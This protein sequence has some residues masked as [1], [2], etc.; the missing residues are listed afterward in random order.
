[1]KRLSFVASIA[2]TFVLLTTNVPADA[3][4]KADNPAH[5]PNKISGTI[6]SS[7]RAVAS[8]MGS[9]GY[10]FRGVKRALRKVGVELHGGQ[11]FMA[12]GQLES[13]GGFRKVPMKNLQPGDI[14]VHGKSGAHPHGHIAVY[15]GNGKE[16]SDHIGKLVTGRRY[17]GTTVFRAVTNDLA[18]ASRKTP[19]AVV[20]K[21]PA[22]T[23]AAVVAKAPAKT[24]A[25]VV[26][27]ATSQEQQPVLVAA[28]ESKATVQ[29][30][31]AAPLATEHAAEQ[32]AQI[33]AANIA[34]QEAAEATEV[35]EAPQAVVAAQPQPQQSFQLPN[36]LSTALLKVV[37]IAQSAHINLTNA[38]AEAVGAI[39]S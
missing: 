21:A 20:A 7:A 22:K 29:L 17:G 34:Q 31:S 18:S 35:V 12:K 9:V 37:E 38:L 4:K 30:A 24:P 8:S 2:A 36:E 33:A 5:K 32:A 11:A 27:T 14:L 28:S 3:V 23:P 16:A 25:A 15:L 6:A 19:A 10:C 1:L 26:A 13:H 39:S